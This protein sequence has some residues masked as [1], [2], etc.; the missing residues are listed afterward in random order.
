MR[1]AMVM[2]A[3]ALERQVWQSSGQI[4]ENFCPGNISV[5]HSGGIAPGKAECCGGHMYHWGALTG[6]ISLLEAGLYE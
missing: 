1:K 2:Q 6:F 5:F 4:C 3:A